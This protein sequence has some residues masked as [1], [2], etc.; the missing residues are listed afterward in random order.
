MDWI[1]KLFYVS[2]A[3]RSKIDLTGLKLNSS[4]W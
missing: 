1:R 4:S 2:K 3:E